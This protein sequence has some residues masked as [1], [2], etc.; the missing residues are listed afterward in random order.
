MDFQ[1]KPVSLSQRLIGDFP[2][3]T[4]IFVFG[5]G[6][7][8]SLIR[9]EIEKHSHLEVEAF[10]DSW[11]QDPFA[12]LPVLAPASLAAFD[13]EE[14]VIILASQYWLEMQ[15]T[16]PPLALTSVYNGAPLIR[17]L[18]EL[19][20]RQQGSSLSFTVTLETQG[21]APQWAAHPA[22]I[23]N[24]TASATN[25][26][27]GLRSLFG[28]FAAVLEKDLWHAAQSFDDW[29]KAPP[30]R[31]SPVVGEPDQD[32]T[33]NIAIVRQD[34]LLTVEDRIRHLASI[35]AAAVENGYL[36]EAAGLSRARHA[37][38]QGDLGTAETILHAL[39]SRRPVDPF[40][41][42]THEN[43]LTALQHLR[44]KQDVPRHLMVYLNGRDADLAQ[45]TCTQ[46]FH[47]FDVQ[48]DGSVLVCCGHWLP[49]PIGNIFREK[50][51]D[52]LNS[53]TARDIRRSVLDGSFRYCNLARCSDAITGSLPLKSEVMD[54]VTKACVEQDQFEV[55]HPSSVI[56]ALDRTCNLSCPSCRSEIVLEKG[57]QRDL[58]ISAVDDVILPILKHAHRL[59]L[60][61]AGEVFASKPSRHLLSKL[62]RE[63]FP[64]LEL[65][66][67]SNGTLFNPEEWSKF[68]GIHGMIG[69]VRISTDAVNAETFEKL[70]RGGDH[71]VFLE[72]MN[73]L[74][75]LRANGTI[76][77]LVTSFT[78]QV[79]NFREMPDFVRW[80]KSLGCDYVNFEKIE[81]ITFSSDEYLEKAVH[82]PTHPL[83]GAFLEVLA[84]PEMQD[85]IVR[86]DVDMTT[87]RRQESVA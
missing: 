77:Q 86:I 37:V 48:T 15:Q 41:R 74:S 2:A 24:L 27:P 76:P 60:N 61:T 63:N 80:C 35:Q 82:K 62:N 9:A 10:I 5:T 68:P 49:K 13:H 66:I 56:F 50:P 4:R 14:T 44:T 52:I 20:Y 87:F 3:G 18:Q 26:D 57:R 16:L 54:P 47:R 11:R 31:Y 28:G 79:D 39:L 81:N 73:F 33:W 42:H 69:Y 53:A 85:E 8:G 65:N 40:V 30:T 21:S 58:K 72:N 51:E 78:Y 70:R 19:S 38:R 32:S 34:D 59:Q 36:H 17:Q 23:R 1:R 46:P 71:G 25:D 84:R 29:L 83:H 67:I 64:Y 7:G 6:Q 45:M 43:T 12:G 75:G 55:D 22:D